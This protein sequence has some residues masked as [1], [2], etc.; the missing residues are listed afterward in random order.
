MSRFRRL[1]TVVLVAGAAAVSLALAGA[2]AGRVADPTPPVITASITGTLGD[3]GWHRSNVTVSWSA[4]DPES[5]VT[6]TRGC[7]TETFTQD[8][9]GVARTCEA[10]NSV[11]LTGSYTVVV[12]IDRTPPTVSA[13]L[14]RAPDVGGWHT[15]PVTAV[16]SG[17][18]GTSSI[19]S[20][21]SPATYSGPDTTG[22]QLTGSCRDRAGNQASASASVK[23]DTT[24]PVV[25]KVVPARRPDRYGW[26]RRP[27]RFAVHGRD[28]TSGIASCNSPVYSGPNDARASVSGTCTDR[29]GNESSPRDATFK[30]ARPLLVPARGSAVQVPVV[31]RWVEV[32]RARLYNVQ[33]WRGKQ[34]LLSVWPRGTSYR[35]GR[36]WGYAGKG[37][38]LVPGRRYRWYVW[39]R[40]GSRYGRLLGSSV[41]VVRRG[42]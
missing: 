32:K 39:P 42:T 10:D 7:D 22:G 9:T 19:A 34:K 23:Y 26:F 8:T 40:I 4:V 27:V 13:A 41:F 3:N 11:G 28:A 5:G 18:D 24:A 33:L 29:A 15:S 20:C 16:F 1:R 12:K 25:T 31:L 2:S 17:S 36:K 21:T 6:R 14:D 37:Y 38:A 30:Y 35:L